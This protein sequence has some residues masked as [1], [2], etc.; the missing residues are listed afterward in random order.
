MIRE[1]D[2][3]IVSGWKKKR[4]DPLI[5]RVTSKVYN[6]TA[7]CPQGLNCMISTVD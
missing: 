7:D 2:F 5:K 1:D 4:Y 3:D 6:G